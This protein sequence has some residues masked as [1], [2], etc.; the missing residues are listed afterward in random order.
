M[1]GHRSD[2]DVVF[3]SW[4]LVAVQVDEPEG[5]RVEP[6][7]DSR[8]VRHLD[9][10]LG[11]VDAVD[12][13]RGAPLDQPQLEAA[14]TAAQAEPPAAARDVVQRHHRE[15]PVGLAGPELGEH[16]LLEDDRVVE[17]PEVL[18]SRANQG[19]LAPEGAHLGRSLRG[20][21]LRL[22]GDLFD[23][24]YLVRDLHGVAAELREPAY[25]LADHVD[26]QHG[27]FDHGRS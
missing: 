3:V 26:H 13:T 24:A 7:L 2:Y 21:G 25:S 17:P 9:G 8:R 12:R 20:P 23:A 4:Q 19:T 10:L 11:N 5:G 1:D 6:A 15:Q 16:A 14:F 27:L 22:D 18:S